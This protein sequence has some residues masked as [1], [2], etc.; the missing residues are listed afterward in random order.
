MYN[1]GLNTNVHNLNDLREQKEQQ[2][3]TVVKHEVLNK[4]N[5]GSN[6]SYPCDLGMIHTTLNLS[7]LIY[8]MRK[9]ILF[10]T[11]EYSEKED[12]A[13]EYLA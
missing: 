9:L 2:W 13:A 11:E 7:F 1:L 8:K 5:S 10:M 12:H 3:S 4:A 6:S